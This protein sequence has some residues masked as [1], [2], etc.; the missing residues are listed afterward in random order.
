MNNIYKIITALLFILI[1]LSHTIGQAQDYPNC[2]SK[3]Q[4]LRMQ[5]TSL[6]DIYGFLNGENWYLASSND[7]VGYYVSGM[8]LQYNVICWTKAGQYLFIYCYSGKPNI[9]NFNTNR[10][11]YESLF[12]S[13]SEKAQGKTITE[14][15]YLKIVFTE[16]N[17]TV[18]F[19]EGYKDSEKFYA[20]NLY[21]TQSVYNEVIKEKKRVTCV[22]S[23]DS[24]Y[25]ESQYTTAKKE[26]E[27]AYRM[28]DNPE[29][30]A[31][32][33]QCEYQLCYN[34]VL[35]GDEYI[36]NQ[37][38]DTAIVCYQK[39]LNCGIRED[40]VNQKIDSCRYLI[41]YKNVLAGDDELRN[42]HYEMAI[43]YYNRS[44]ICGIE[45]KIVQQ[46]IANVQKIL[47]NIKINALLST[48]DSAFSLREYEKAETHYNE[49]LA[50]DNSNKTALKGINRVKEIRELLLKRQTSI[51]PYNTVDVNNYALYNTNINNLLNNYTD[52]NKKGEIDFQFKIFYDTSGN[53]LS[54]YT[55]NHATLKNFTNE[56]ETIKKFVDFPAPSLSGYFVSAQHKTDIDLKWQTKRYVYI[57]NRKSFKNVNDYQGNQKAVSNFINQ[58]SY[59]YGKYTFEMKEKKL[60]QDT[61]FT[62]I[63]L[64][65]YKTQAGPANCLLSFLIPG[66]GS[67]KISQGKKG[68]TSFS[69]VILSSCI[70]IGTYLYAKDQYRLYSQTGDP[71]YKEEADA[72][73]ILSFGFM[74]LAAG[75]YIA[76]IITVFSKGIKNLKATK[77][78]RSQLH[79]A[80]IEIQTEPVKVN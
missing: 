27:K 42:E 11:C 29:V 16:K 51:F 75:F 17:V 13:F 68:W 71:K 9:V 58:Q 61:L 37:N 69:V 64:I 30:Y 78:L 23:G 31:K 54:S 28:K 26:Y 39:A 53:N 40:F 4:L 36:R 74:G 49:V 76:D 80:P 35:E 34:H 60:N 10:W 22:L 2:Y 25:A 32:I 45:K 5:S 79:S 77:A 24:L 20:V 50:L 52:K 12:A 6:N 44:E 56:L 19:I 59:K 8:T 47:K 70:G 41:C 66:L 57:N 1:V 21:N 73:R 67:M 14:D 48:A 33:K 72:D 15:G 65:K 55:F 7:D 38:Y 63:K 3:P 46:K 18:E 43:Q 62:D